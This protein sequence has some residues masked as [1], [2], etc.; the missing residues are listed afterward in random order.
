[1][2]GGGLP[3]FVVD[4]ELVDGALVVE[5]DTLELVHEDLAGVDGLYTRPR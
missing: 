2:G 3:T 1:V 4:E 5:D